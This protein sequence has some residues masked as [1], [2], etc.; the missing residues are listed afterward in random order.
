MPAV[1]VGAVI[2]AVELAGIFIVYDP[3]PLM[4][5]VTVTG[6]FADL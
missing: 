4:L 1:P 6:N 3:L 2:V 5:Y